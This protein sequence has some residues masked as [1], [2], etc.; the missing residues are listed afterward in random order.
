[1]AYLM[2]YENYLKYNRSGIY[3]IS[4]VYEGGGCKLLYVGQS[5]N[6][7]KRIQ[8]HVRE[9]M[10]EQPLARKYQL[11]HNYWLS[12]QENIER[13]IQFDVLEYCEVEE[14]DEMEQKWIDFFQP[15]LNTLGMTDGK[16]ID[17]RLSEDEEIFWILDLPTGWFSWED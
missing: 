3:S 16:T 4:I 11:L 7:Y 17:Q 6:M 15:A 9:M 10:K 5:K 2:N 1:M 13:K 12:T 14:L 8:S